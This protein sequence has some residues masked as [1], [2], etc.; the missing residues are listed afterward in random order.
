M[1][2]SDIEDAVAA[3]QLSAAQTFTQMRQHVDRLGGVDTTTPTGIEHVKPSR[4]P[5]CYGDEPR[6]KTILRLMIAAF[7]N[8]DFDTYFTLN[9]TLANV[10]MEIL[11]ES[12]NV[13]A[14]DRP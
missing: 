3:N 8:G 1:S 2:I 5:A 9:E 10:H 7:D 11:K 13:E 14:T 6:A 4:E 12:H